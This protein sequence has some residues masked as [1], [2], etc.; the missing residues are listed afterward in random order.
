MQNISKFFDTDSLHQ[1]KVQEFIDNMNFLKA[2]SAEEHTLYKKYQ[3]INHRFNK[4]I[5]NIR[6]VK[7][8]I[9]KP[10]NLQDKQITLE[11]LENMKPRVIFVNDENTLFDWSILRD[12]SHSMSFDANI[13]R[14][15]KYLVID[16]YTGKYI[17]VLNVGSD[18]IAIKDRDAWIGWNKEIRVKEKKI[19]NTAIGNCIMP[20]QPF[21][22][23]FLGGKLMAV[24]ITSKLVRDT[25][26]ERYQ[27]TIVGF[28]T[29]S[30]YGSYSM[31]NNIPYWK[32]VGSSAGKILIKPDDKVYDYMLQYIK[33]H[34]RDEYDAIQDGNNNA[35]GV[36]S[37]LKQRLLAPIFDEVGLKMSDYTHGYQR[38]VYFAAIY[39]NAREFL[40][41]TIDE[42]KL[43]MKPRYVQDVDGMVEWWKDKA[44][45]RYE[46][47]HSENRLNPE[48]LFY[49]GM[50]G[51]TWNE[52][53]RAYL[54]DIGR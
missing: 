23:N 1:Q 29:T 26:K 11:Q 40:C 19:N 10:I 16:D 44:I 33:E 42:S 15:M 30:L 25:W 50:I 38:G 27:D 20:T 24:L 12:F 48:I 45:K 21:G 51:M 32:A 3:D 17:G 6:I 8:K 2:M 14:N 4:E 18:A 53:K 52:S 5:A 34:R 43:V 39:E 36:T 46:K 37:G 31:Y 7:N 49:D 35:I 54:E 22:Y 13:G 47:L 9:W 41:K 28:T